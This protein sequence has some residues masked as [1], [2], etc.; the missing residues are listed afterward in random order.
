M[1]ELVDL[2]AKLLIGTFSFIGPSFTLFISLFYKQFE[3]AKARHK[4]MLPILATLDTTDALKKQ[5]KKFERDKKRGSPKL[6]LLIVFGCLLA[7]LLMIGFYYFQHSHF[8]TCKYQSIRIATIMVSIALFLYSLYTLWQVFCL[9]INA[10]SEDERG[11][12]ERTSS[13]KPLN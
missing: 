1:K 6:Q 8:W 13:L 11:S 12:R 5:I 9:I 10:K 7:S 2:Y 3:R 4:E